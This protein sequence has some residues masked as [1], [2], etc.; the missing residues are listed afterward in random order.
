MIQQKKILHLNI[1]EFTDTVAYYQ[2]YCCAAIAFTM[3][4]EDC[5]CSCNM[6][7]RIL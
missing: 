5:F 2:E 6:S 1:M 3:I 4:V 7:A